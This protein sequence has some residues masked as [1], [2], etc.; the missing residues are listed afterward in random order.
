M[1][2]FR[3]WTLVSVILGIA[4]LGNGGEIALLPPQSVLSGAGGFAAVAGGECE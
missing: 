3:S 2:R 4:S 1:N